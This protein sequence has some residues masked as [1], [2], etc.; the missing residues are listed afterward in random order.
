MSYWTSFSIH[1]LHDPTSMIT[2]VTYIN[3][4]FLINVEERFI[5]F[6]WQTTSARYL[7]YIGI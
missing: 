6:H 4:Q 7:H 3:K 5:N 1:I 2:K